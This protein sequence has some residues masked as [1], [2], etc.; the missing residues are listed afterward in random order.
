[1]VQGFNSENSNLKKFFLIAIL[2]ITFIA[3]IVYFYSQNPEFFNQLVQAYGMPGLFIATVIANATIILP[4]PIDIFIFLLADFPFFPFGIFNPFLLAI[5]IALA[6]TIG[7]MSGYLIGLFGVT[8]LEKMYTK[9]ISRIED[10]ELSLHKF[11]TI[12]IVLGALTP[13]PFD[14]IGIAAGLLRFDVKKFFIACYIGKFFR[15]LIIAYAG[16]YSLGFI[17]GIFGF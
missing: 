15:Y 11:G 12:I 9:S 1:M 13:F 2:L 4:I 8:S 16:F 14:V 17:R 7:E 10:M 6:A 3:I 5:I